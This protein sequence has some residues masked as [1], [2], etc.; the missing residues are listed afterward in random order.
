[1]SIIHIE[2][3]ENRPWQSAPVQSCTDEELLTLTGETRQTV[4]GFGGCFNELGWEA[5]SLLSGD[6]RRAVLDDFFGDSL[7]LTSGRLP[8]GANDFS[9]EWYS[10]D[11]TPDDLALDHFNIDRDRKYTIPFIRE[12]LKRCPQ[13]HLFASPWSPPTWM[14][15]HRAYNYGTMR[16][17]PAVLDAYARYFVKFVQAY[18]GEGIEIAQIHVQNEPVADQKFP[19]CVW[20]GEKLRVFIRDYIGPAFRDA[21]LSTELWLGT[22]NAPFT[23]YRGFMDVNFQEFFDGMVNTVLADPEARRYLT[24]VG[25]QWGGKHVLEPLEAA[26]PEMRVMQTESDCGNGLNEWEQAEYIFT[27]MWQYFRHGAERY[28]YW[29]LALQDGGISTWGWKQNS[30]ITVNP[31]SR[32]YRFQPEYYLMK[33]FSHFIQPGARF[34]PLRGHWAS[35]ALAFENPDGAIV[36]CACNGVGYERTLSFRCERGAFSCAIAPHTFH[37]FVLR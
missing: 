2:S 7:N 16:M 6:D 10:C 22:I 17:E 19:S 32:T 31:D 3:A 14:K 11:E 8:I 27:L 25:L 5:L 24:G 29:N 28:T 1:M 34:R 4:L 13:L 36:L 12:A 30:L 37:T 35:S 26:Y 20:T 33:H 18:A 23:D 15:T 9:L 21:G